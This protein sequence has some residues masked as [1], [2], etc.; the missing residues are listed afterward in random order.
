LRDFT[1]AS[2]N[3]LP[4]H[5]N[6]F[7]RIIYT[8]ETNITIFSSLIIILS[9]SIFDNYNDKFLLFYIIFLIVS[10]FYILSYASI[11]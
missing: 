6:M 2:D 10:K 8:Y 1:P 5:I 9:N 7:G 11:Y 4:S 3:Y